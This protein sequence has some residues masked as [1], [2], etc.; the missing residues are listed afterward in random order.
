MKRIHMK[1]A[2]VIFI[3]SFEC[4]MLCACATIGKNGQKNDSNVEYITN[5]YSLTKEDKRTEIHLVDESYK[6]DLDDVEEKVLLISKAGDYTLSGTYYGQIQ[7]SIDDDEVVH[8]FMDGANVYSKGGPAIY[9]ESADKLVITMLDGTQN[10]LS[11]SVNYKGYEEV[12]S[13]IYSNAD[14]SFNGTGILNIYGYY[15]DAIKSKGYVKLVDGNVQIRSKDIGIRANDGILISNGNLDIQSEGTGIY[16]KNS[17]VEGKGV[18]E[19][20]SGNISIIS[21]QNAIYSASDV[22][23]FDGQVFVNSVEEKIKSGGKQYIK[24]GCLQ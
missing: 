10:I 22:H 7:I 9:V 11:D 13:S 5:A 24:E 15:N 21:G 2:C 6:I 8:L 20:L 14:I 12:K 16:T 19:I 17:D 23:I 3:I 4:M 1:V 18:V